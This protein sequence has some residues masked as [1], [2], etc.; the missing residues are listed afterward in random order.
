MAAVQLIFAVLAALLGYTLWSLKPLIEDAGIFA[1]S[2]KNF[3]VDGCIKIQGPRVSEKIVVNHRSGI[4]FMIS[5][6]MDARLQWDPPL[7]FWNETVRRMDSF[8]KYDIKKGIATKLKLRNFPYDELV[9]LGF[10]VWDP[11]YPTRDPYS[12]DI[13]PNVLTLIA[14][15]YKHNTSSIEIFEHTLGTDEL[16]H[17]ERVEDRA[18]RMPNDVLAIGRRQFYV[19]NYR[20]YRRG[21][22]R[23]VETYT[24]RHWGN[25]VVRH[26]PARPMKIVARHIGYANG[27]AAN[28]DRS[29]VYVA[30]LLERRVH[31]YKRSENDDSLRQID[32]VHVGFLVDNLSVDEIT[33]EIYAAG[34]SMALYILGVFETVRANPHS[35][36]PPAVPSRVVKIFN[37]TGS[38]RFYGIKYSFDDVLEDDGKTLT[39]VSS[40]AIDGER[41]VLLI[42]NLLT[43]SYACPRNPSVEP[44][45]NGEAEGGDGGEDEMEGIF[46]DIQDMLDD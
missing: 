3:G 22:L 7:N 16:V 8:Y 28:W 24:M 31:I 20:Y 42:G 11:L 46:E 10:D 43:D 23:A 34:V 2:V 5:S 25:V 36:T 40:A 6:D 27:L 13:D 33:G 12:T 37:N 17:V 21:F 26:D 9:L 32:F 30:A 14:I 38:D 45:W 18:L 39:F 4:A 44:Y 29:L 41:G 1:G 15:N 19:T 35:V